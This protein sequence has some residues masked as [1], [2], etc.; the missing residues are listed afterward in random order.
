MQFHI[1]RGSL[2]TR[3][4]IG[5]QVYPRPWTFHHKSFYCSRVQKSVL[6]GDSGYI[7]G[8][9]DSGRL[10][11]RT[12]A[13]E[14]VFAR[15]L[16]L[17]AFLCGPSSEPTLQ[18]THPCALTTINSPWLKRDTDARSMLHVLQED[19]ELSCTC[20]VFL[21]LKSGGAG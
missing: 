20:F 6:S 5:C 11:L 14:I 7:T 16:G 12:V 9:V 1:A 3:T 19:E 13:S 4:S 18:A 10:T 15:L 8:A 21:Q 2:T 17:P